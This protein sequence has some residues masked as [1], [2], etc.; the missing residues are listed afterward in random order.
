M[1]TFGK[2]LEAFILQRNTTKRK[3]CQ[4]LGVHEN[5]INKYAGKNAKSILGQIY[6]A[7][8]ADMGLNIAWYLT[9]QGEMLIKEEEE[10]TFKGVP[11]YDIDVSASI[12]TSLDDMLEV[13]Q[14]FIDY[15][16]LN[17]CIAYF[18]VYGESMYPRYCSGDLIGVI[19]HH[20]HDV[21]MWGDPYLIIT[22]AYAN[23]LRTI[24]LIFKHDDDD[25]VILRASNP[26]HAGDIVIKKENI[27]GL[28]LVRGRLSQEHM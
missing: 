22:D 24:K 17:D 11:F 4:E 25:K 2:R 20:N 21:I 19:K 27:L 12:V 9:G 1:D 23:N 5:S 6:Q 26:A 8:L 13:P 18:R 10:K 28:Y 15:K 14:Y 16:P 3:F 7:K